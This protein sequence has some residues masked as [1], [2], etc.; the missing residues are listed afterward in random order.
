MIFAPAKINLGLRITGRYANGYH[1]LESLFIPLTL[2]DRITVRLAARDEVVH[3][4]PA[5]TPPQA[6]RELGLGAAKNPL[7]IGALALVRD[8]LREQTGDEL[9]P[10]LVT[11]TKRIPS[12][13]GLGGA[14]ADAAALIRLLLNHHLIEQ[15][16]E[17]FWPAV[18]RI[19]ADVPFFLRYGLRGKSALLQGIGHELSG[20][21]APLLAGVVAI[22]PFG[23]STQLMF[24]YV[25][26][27]ELP[28]MEAKPMTGGIDF[29]LRLN[30]IPCSDELAVGVRHVI[31]D[32]DTAAEAVFPIQFALLQQAKRTM[33]FAASQMLA[34]EWF[35]GMTGS[36]AGLFALTANTVTADALRW[37]ANVLRA[38]LSGWQVFPVRSHTVSDIGP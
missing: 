1:H 22:P 28:R 6:R 25:R 17:T 23:F 35:V 4:W 11:L 18:T 38:R 32:F 21:T 15:P 5:N 8:F 10:L 34:R 36:G 33:A 13:S 14:S 30:E 12:P 31:N 2:Y 29:T 7:L 37:M 16:P 27:L 3:H 9:P 20:C 19:G 26:K 24:A